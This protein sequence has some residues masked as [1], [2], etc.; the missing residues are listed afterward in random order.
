MGWNSVREAPGKMS[1]RNLASLT[2]TTSA[3]KDGTASGYASTRAVAT[4]FFMS[5]TMDTFGE[6]TSSTAQSSVYAPGSSS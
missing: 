1:Q 2:D 4:F 5:P 6:Y 3:G